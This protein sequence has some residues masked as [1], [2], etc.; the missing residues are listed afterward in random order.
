MINLGELESCGMLCT[1]KNVSDVKRLLTLMPMWANFSAYCLIA[2]IGDTSFVEQSNNLKAGS[3]S[4]SVLFFLRSFI[5]LA[6][7]LPFGWEKVR[8]KCGLLMRIGAGM[9]CSIA[10]CIVAWKVEVH[11]LHLMEETRSE[12]DTLSMSVYSLIPQYLLLG[13]MEGLAGDGLEEFVIAHIPDSMRRYGPVFSELVLG[14]GYFYSIPL[15][16][17][18]RSFGGTNHLE[19]YFLFLAILSSFFFVIYVLSFSKYAG[20]EEIPSE[21]IESVKYLEDGARESI[22]LKPTSSSSSVRWRRLAEVATAS[23]AT[24]K[25]THSTKIVPDGK[26]TAGTLEDSFVEAESSHDESSSSLSKYAGMEEIPSEDIE[27]VKYLED[28]ARESIELKPTSSSS[29][30]RWRRLAEVATTSLATLKATHSTKVVPDGKLTA[31]TLEDSF[32]EADSSHDE[33]SSLL[34]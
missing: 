24:L 5:R 21:D 12:E 10:C 13:L 28:G 16:F 6:I 9:V 17:L 33:P 18:F 31:G 27:S 11:R 7:K 20:M 23:L 19:I 32:V 8:Q 30:V 34:D 29:S 3:L 4:L 14:F 26:L 15:L 22:E 1:V 2:P 25:A